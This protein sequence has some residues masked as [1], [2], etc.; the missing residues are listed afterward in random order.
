MKSEEEI[1]CSRRQQEGYSNGKEYAREYGFSI[2]MGYSID[3][4]LTTFAQ[5]IKDAKTP[6]DK[7]Y[8]TGY[9]RGFKD[10]RGIA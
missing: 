1:R 4:T 9:D 2:A 7:A 5:C 6:E 10:G 3:S 8:Y